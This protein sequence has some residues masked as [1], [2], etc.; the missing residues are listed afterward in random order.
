MNVV[1]QIRTAAEQALGI[2]VEQR[3]AAAEAGRIG[4]LRRAA[5]TAFAANG[6]PHRRVEEWKYTDLRALQR[7]AAPLAGTPDAAAVAAASA[8]VMS[9]EGAPRI[10][11]VN[12]TL[13]GSA[14]DLALGAGITVEP[15]DAALRGPL[16][17]RV[18]ALAPQRY[19]GPLALNTVFL[20]S[21]LV[22]RVAAGA[23]IETPLHIANVFT[24]AAA[25]TYG[26]VVLVV[27]EGAE[28]TL[29]ESFQGPDG[30]AYQTNS[31]LE[32]FVG[33]E[34]HADYIRVQE[35]GDAALH[36]A[37]LM[38][39]IGRNAQLHTF[40]FTSGAKASRISLYG[41]FGG[42]HS[43]AGLNGVNLLKNKQHA[44]VTLLLDHAV[45]H[46]ESRELFK[47]VLADESHGVFQGKIVV[48]PDAQKTDGRMMSRALLLGETAEMDNKPELEIF[49][50]DV[51][52]GHGATVGDLDETL[53][54]YLKAR[55]IPQK[56]AE[57]LLVQAF[58]GEALELLENETLREFL[59]ARA[60][61]WLVR[62]AG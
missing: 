46:C 60:A 8:D 25:S 10:L 40:S 28:V 34:A 61:A 3:T 23:K 26:R 9:I 50:D 17:D 4:E 45:P 51:Q 62:R 13:V 55:G 20:G 47:S 18:G 30:V 22:V 39:E 37:T 53:L 48:H 31:A 35:E 33:D 58:V 15:L 41:R 32:L 29:V 11:F 5:A 21:G 56:E 54:F 2:A 14:S 19:D 1:T 43:Q 59:I 16:A 38:T 52:C 6:L 7:E 44:D 57:A 49:A 24:G 12:G 36:L 27:E 42:Q